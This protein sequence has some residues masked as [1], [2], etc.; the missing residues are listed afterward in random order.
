MAAIIFC[1]FAFLLQQQ[2]FTQQKRNTK[3]PITIAARRKIEIVFSSLM[4]GVAVGAEEMVGEVVGENEIEG[5]DVGGSVVG[6]VDGWPDGELL[7]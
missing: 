5:C 1:L 7:G 6:T 2:D 4:D 3:D